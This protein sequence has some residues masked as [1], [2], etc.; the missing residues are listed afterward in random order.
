MLSMR[1]THG[2]QATMRAATAL[3]VGTRTASCVG[4]GRRSF[5]SCATLRTQAPTAAPVPHFRRRRKKPAFLDP[6][7]FFSSA[8]QAVNNILY[9]TPTAT[10]APITRHVL[11]CLVSNEPG[12]LSHVS[13]TLAGRG[14]NI[15]SLVVAKTEVADLS[16]MTIVLSGQ[17][18]V[19]EQA[20][21][22][23]EDMVPVWAVLDF[24]H[25]RIVERE[26]L[27][28]KV[29]TVPKEHAV[30]FDYE[31]HEADEQATQSTLSPLLGAA[32]QRQAITELARLFKA[33]VT[34][35]SIDGII[36]ELTAKPDRIDAFMKLLKPFGIIEAARS[37]AMAMPRS[38]VDGVYEDDITVEEEE[39]EQHGKIDATMLP[40]G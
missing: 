25:G 19:I 29:S 27:L 12:V 39:E 7:P 6:E 2:G 5:A 9:N 4:A 10:Q 32:M 35:V 36:I 24:T 28:V 8:E 38:P 17:K 37:G 23:L 16:R 34:D 13:G 15:E 1:S 20:R 40:P 21:R 14:F 31:S 26:M 11:N 33:R 22:Q 3:Y 30:H 18:A